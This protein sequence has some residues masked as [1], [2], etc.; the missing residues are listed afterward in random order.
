MDAKKNTQDFEIDE[1]RDGKIRDEFL[2]PENA[3]SFEVI[4]IASRRYYCR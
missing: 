3:Y 2:Y 1:F 4:D